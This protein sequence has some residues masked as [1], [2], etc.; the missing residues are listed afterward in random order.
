MVLLDV[1]MKFLIADT[2]QRR[3]VDEPPAG[4]TA[5]REVGVIS[6]VEARMLGYQP[7]ADL[8]LQNTSTS[9]R[10]WIELEISR[11]DPAANHVKFGSAHLMNPL[12]AGDAF[13][14]LV[15]R[16][17]TLGR[18][19]LAAHAVWLLRASGLRA[20]QMP[21]LPQL[22]ATTIKQLN[23]GSLSL[24]RIP[25]PDL[26]EILLATVPDGSSEGSGIYRV[27]NRLEVI[28]NIHQWNKDMVSEDTRAAWGRR[29]V[30]YF[31]HDR[32]SHLFAPSKFAAYTRIPK[33]PSSDEPL[34]YNP[35]MTVRAYSKV[36][37]DT[38]I[39]DGRKAW[40][41]ISSLGFQV[42]KARDCP[43]RIQ[44]HFRSWLAIHENALHC[45]LDEAEILIENS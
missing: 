32:S 35:A 26:G 9:Q 41:R 42:T 39:F 27:T 34:P 17:V 6:A 40:Q 33:V 37:H 5:S 44:E 11:A 21:L 7:K 45:S 18:S 1:F 13:V 8:M 30:R 14:S 31:V 15:S 20:F 29:R 24:D 28:L 43:S 36:P 25:T 12:P 10:V 3:W 2:L 23:Q 4:W 38:P 16:H 22:D 19:N